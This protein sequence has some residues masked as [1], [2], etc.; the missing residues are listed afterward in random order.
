MPSFLSRM[1]VFSVWYFKHE[2]NFLLG[3]TLD[4]AIVKKKCWLC[5]FST[6]SKQGFCFSGNV[7]YLSSNSHHTVTFVW[8]EFP[9]KSLFLGNYRVIGKRKRERLL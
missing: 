3:A 9:S 7:L 8:P 6:N 1:V 4:I 2:N 5:F